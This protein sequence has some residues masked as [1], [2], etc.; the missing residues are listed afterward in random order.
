MAK[1]PIRAL[2]T[3]ETTAVATTR[4]SLCSSPIAMLMMR[5]LTGRMKDMVKKVTVPAR[6]SVH[7]VT[8][9]RFTK[10]GSARFKW[11]TSYATPVF[12]HTQDLQPDDCSVCSVF[13]SSSMV[14]SIAVAASR[15]V[16]I[17][18]RLRQ[19]FF[20]LGDPVVE[21]SNT[22]KVVKGLFRIGRRR[23]RASVVL[24]GR[25][26]VTMDCG[27]KRLGIACSEKNT[28]HSDP[29]CGAE[30]GEGG[31]EALDEEHNQTSRKKMNSFL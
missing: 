17:A 5:A 31:G 24:R 2:D 28:H 11:A 6:I 3:A 9:L 18:R 16:S 29:T 1:R 21:L 30:D 13:G 7:H 23:R 22:G 27:E 14:G 26:A 15:S 10:N 12:S 25:L 20:F 8:P 19:F 4:S